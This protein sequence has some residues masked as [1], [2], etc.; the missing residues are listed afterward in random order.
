MKAIQIHEFGDADVMRYED[1]PDPTPAAGEVVIKVGAIGVNPVDTYIRAGVHLIKPELPYTP[2]G[3]GAGTILS[4]GDGVGQFE[5]GDRVYVANGGGSGCYAEQVA[6]PADR[7][8]PLPDNVSF[9]Q[10]AAIGTPYGT[11][12]WALV[13]R[14]RGKAGETVLVHGASGAVGTAA[15]QIAKSMGINTIGTAGSER[16]LELVRQQGAAHALDHTRDGYLDI[17]GE[18]TDGKGP[19]LILEM[20]ANVNLPRDMEVVAKY[21][22]I[23]VIG[24]RGPVEINPREA[25]MKELDILGIARFNATPDEMAGLNAAIGRGLADGSLAPVIGK[26]LPLSQAIEAHHAVLQPGA[27][28]KIVLSP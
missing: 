1:V 14:G 8:M 5:I 25:M 12:Y 21:G 20:L 22:R 7:I 15:L 24:N 4:L 9:A 17:I 23:V 3:D 27:Y 16:G 2:G 6:L 13:N 28:G 19:D 18:L 10:G 11:A 26:E